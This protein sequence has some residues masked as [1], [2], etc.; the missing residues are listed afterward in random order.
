[1]RIWSLHPSYLDTK[2]L[3]ALWR[4]TLLAQ[5][6]LPKDKGGYV[7]HPQ[8][9]RFKACEDS[10]GAIGAYLQEI[11]LEAEKRNFKFA[12]NKILHINSNIKIP[13]SSGQINYEMEHLRNKLKVRDPDKYKLIESITEIKLHPLFYE[14]DGPVADWEVITPQKK[15][16]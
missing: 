6:V 5:S 16:L 11:F 7:N 8:L 2:G 14:T 9:N 10:M 4:E 13:V 12:G 15:I 1:M 3:L